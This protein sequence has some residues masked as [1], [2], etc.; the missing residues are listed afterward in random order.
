MSGM[1]RMLAMTVGYFVVISGGPVAGQSEIG[2][3][4]REH[5][6]E[7]RDLRVGERYG[8]GTRVRSPF[9]GLSF[10]IPG[11]GAHP[12]RLEQLYF[13]IRP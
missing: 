4:A 12:F 9:V 5:A 13:S 7:I 10:V 11:T 3:V 8:G 2:P 6:Q 1:I